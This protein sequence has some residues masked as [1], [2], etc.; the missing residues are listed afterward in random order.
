[1]LTNVPVALVQSEPAEWLHLRTLVLDSVTSPNSKR[2]YGAAVD[3]F[4]AWYGSEP[5]PPLSK[6]VVNAYRAHLEVLGL[7]AST[8]NVKLSAVRKLATEAADTA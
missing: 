4:F 6:V 8:I 3:D 2:A 5:R 7:V 1:M